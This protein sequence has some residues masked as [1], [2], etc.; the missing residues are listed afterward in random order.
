MWRGILFS[1]FLVLFSLSGFAFGADRFSMI[2]EYQLMDGCVEKSAAYSARL[3]KAAM[4]IC[5]CA[6]EKTQENGWYP[7]YD[8]DQD[9]VDD[10]EEFMTDFGKNIKECRES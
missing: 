7:D 10:E 4:K 9:F 8:H 2:L 5:A 3:R 1:F 6:L